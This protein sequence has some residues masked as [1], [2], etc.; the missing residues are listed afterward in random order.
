MMPESVVY[1]AR[2]SIESRGQAEGPVR[3]LTGQWYTG[4]NLH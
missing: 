1:A 2:I 4:Y 3:K